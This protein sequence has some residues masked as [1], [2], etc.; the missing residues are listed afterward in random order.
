MR[1]KKILFSALGCL[2]VL[3]LGV[4]F[5]NYLN[6]VC[7][8]SLSCIKDLSGIYQA[9]NKGTYLGKEIS[10]PSYIA[11]GIKE[12]QKVVLGESTGG[13][14]HIYIDLSTQQLSAYEGNNMVFSFPISSGKWYPT[15]TGDFRIWIKLRYTR[16]AGGNPAIGT[17]YNLPN[18]PF[19]MFFYSS[20]VPKSR[21]FGLH[22]AYWHNNF[23]HPMSHGCVNISIQN[24]EK[25]YN[26]ADP[27]TGGNV[28]YASDENQGTPITIYG[29]APKE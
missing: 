1:K 22:G 2:A 5:Y 14:K 15:P 6:P 19:T 7:A 21:G 8:N 28:T 17:Y 29:V 9:D 26:W 23:G 3:L 13:N 11:S 18:V 24:A 10:G 20:T 16:M 27:P 25:L 12:V 4:S